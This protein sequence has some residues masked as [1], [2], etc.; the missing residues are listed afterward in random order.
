[1]TVIVLSPYETSAQEFFTAIQK[2]K[3]QIV[4]DVRLHNT[5]QLAGFSKEGD[6]AYF[7]PTICGIPYIHDTR[8]APEESLLSSYLKNSLSFD[9]YSRKYKEEIEREGGRDLFEKSYPYERVALIGTTTKKRHS[10]AETLA[11]MLEEK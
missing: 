2:A 4:V 10:H 7:V 8:F 6:L 11:T 1:M 5:N 9:R 3:A